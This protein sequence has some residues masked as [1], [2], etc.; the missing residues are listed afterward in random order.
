LSSRLEVD[1]EALIALSRQLQDVRDLLAQA[2]ASGLQT[3]A[4][5]EVLDALGDFED[6]WRALTRNLCDALGGLG[7]GVVRA[8]REFLDVDARL[9]RLHRTLGV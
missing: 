9:A 1:A 7:D 4:H 8:A 6:G 5:R 2:S 3:K